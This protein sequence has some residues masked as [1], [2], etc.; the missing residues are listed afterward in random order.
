MTAAAD[1]RGSIERG[2]RRVLVVEDERGIQTLLRAL[3][4]DEGYEV[5]IAGTGLEALDLLGEWL[6]DVILL[7]LT[8]PEMGG[9]MFRAAQLALD[10]PAS[11]VPVIL[12]TGTHAAGRFVETL[13]AAAFVSKPFDLD[14]LLNAVA[15]VI[16][17]A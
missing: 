6:P 4:T 17:A 9:A 7:D 8:L 3:L 11:A 10:P 15:R 2:P 12:V 1:A 13:R 14:D 16:S 5:R